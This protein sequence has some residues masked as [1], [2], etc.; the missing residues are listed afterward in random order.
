MLSQGYSQEDF[1]NRDIDSISSWQLTITTLI[2][3]TEPSDEDEKC[4]D[5]EASTDWPGSD[6]IYCRLL[7]FL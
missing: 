4:P 5:L 7:R 1:V 6:F 2:A 3:I